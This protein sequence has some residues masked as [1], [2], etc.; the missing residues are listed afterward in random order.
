M[1]LCPT[2]DIH[3]VYLDN[4]LPLSY[5]KEYEAH[6]QSCSKCSAELEKLKKLRGVMSAGGVPEM[7]QFEMDESFKRLQ[8]R[9]SYSKHTKSFNSPATGWKHAA[10]STVKYS[11][12][13]MAA[14]AVLAI[15]LPIGLNKANK[16]NAEQTDSVTS[17]A[18][19]PLI[20]GN[21]VSTNTGLSGFPGTNG[22]MGNITHGMHRDMMRPGVHSGMGNENMPQVVDVFRPNFDNE[23]TISIKITIP[24]M[25]TVPYTTEI[26]VPVDEYKANN[27]ETD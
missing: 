12:P 23:N 9:M 3:S 18:S 6:V 17:I 2:K 13:A 7:S 20:S 19:L 11:I 15:V 4:E 25:N 21:T 24:G 26:N 1:S 8:I 5:V 22:S 14:A 27:S 16:G 10:I